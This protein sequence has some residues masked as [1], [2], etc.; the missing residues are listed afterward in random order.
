MSCTYVLTKGARAGTVCGSTI[1]LK[2][3][4]NDYYCYN[5]L[6]TKGLQEHLASQGITP[7]VIANTPVIPMKSNTLSG[8]SG[9]SNTQTVPRQLNIKPVP[10][11]PAN[12]RPKQEPKQEPKKNIFVT[13]LQNG[14]IDYDKLYDQFH[15]QQFDEMPEGAKVPRIIKDSPAKQEVVSA[16]NKEQNQIPTRSED[17]DSDSESDSD[18]EYDPQAR[19]KDIDPEERELIKTR[20]EGKLSDKIALGE[21]TAKAVMC[22]AVRSLALMAE[23]MAN[24][25]L[26]GLK[27]VID[28][29]QEFDLVMDQLARKYEEEYGLANLPPEISL[30]ILLGMM[31]SHV[32]INNNYMTNKLPKSNPSVL[33]G[34]IR[35]PVPKNDYSPAYPD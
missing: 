16:M 31:T 24:P 7:D 9:K 2:Q 35:K 5:H 1:S 32:Y 10:Q 6:K 15:N 27:D 19:Y 8:L 22:T 3:F 30:V 12:P 20:K 29:N 17:S 25:S 34:L 26:D 23:Q 14:N 18:G 21:F 28:A 13:E 11:A 4:G 33:G